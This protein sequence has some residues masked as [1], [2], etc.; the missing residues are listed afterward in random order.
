MRS[1]ING[2]MTSEAA[3]ANV[4]ESA[5]HGHRRDTARIIADEQDLREGRQTKKY[6]TKGEPV[7]LV[8][9]CAMR[10]ENL[11]LLKSRMRNTNNELPEIGSRE[12]HQ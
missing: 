5:A 2:G 4:P 1:R 11:M 3:V 8:Q 7:I 12:I 10:A 6:G 9:L